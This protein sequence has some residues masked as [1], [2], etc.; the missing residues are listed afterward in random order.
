VR[1]AVLPNAEQPAR[2]PCGSRSAAT[3]FEFGRVVVPADPGA[4]V[5]LVDIARRNGTEVVDYDVR[6]SRA[7]RRRLR[8]RLHA[9]RRSTRGKSA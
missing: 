4:D 9:I 7:V 6:P 8:E 3:L 1:L 2:A 5:G